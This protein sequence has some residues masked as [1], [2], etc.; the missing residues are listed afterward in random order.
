MNGISTPIVF[1][2]PEEICVLVPFSL[3]GV[4]S[5]TV[6]VKNQRGLSNTQTVAMADAAPTI[7]SLGSDGAGQGFALDSIGTLN[8][9]YH[10]VSRGA[11]IS[12]WGTGGGITSTP[13]ADGQVYNTCCPSP[14]P[15]R[16]RS[17]GSMPRS[18]M[19]GCLEEA[20]VLCNQRC[21][22]HWSGARNRRAAPG[23]CR[24]AR[25]SSRHHNGY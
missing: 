7:F 23:C 1:A 20:P 15:F 21:R 16:F 19:L 3:A 9:I 11:V 13:I 25:I 6:Q 10:P 2:E 5:V 4:S 12:I 14:A 18:L 17:A 22:P 8:S 24:G